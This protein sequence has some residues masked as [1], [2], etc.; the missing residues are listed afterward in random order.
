MCKLFFV[1]V[2]LA[3]LC[4][5]TYM[6]CDQ[7]KWV[8]TRKREIISS[9]NRIVCITLRA[10][11]CWKPHQYRTYGSK[12]IAICVLLK[13]ASY[14]GNRVLLFAVSRNQYKRSS[15][16][17]CLIKSQIPCKGFDLGSWIFRLKSIKV[18]SNSNCSA[19]Y[20]NDLFWTKHFNT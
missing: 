5:C 4:T 20:R 19:N 11:F 2:I 17:F 15:D 18:A 7:V 14:K 10:I 6:W 8:W 1:V 16:S 9:F 3:A 12:V 13:T